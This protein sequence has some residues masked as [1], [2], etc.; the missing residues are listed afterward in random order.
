MKLLFTSK[1]ITFLLLTKR[2]LAVSYTVT[3][4]EYSKLAVQ[5]SISLY[6]T[7]KV[8]Q[9]YLRSIQTLVFYGY[10]YIIII[11]SN[12]RVTV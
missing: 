8:P 4:S 12:L 3:D 5:T 6:Y 10:L 1:V 11:V 7:L 2:T 9:Y